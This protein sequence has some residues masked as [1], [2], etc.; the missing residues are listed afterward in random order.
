MKTFPLLGGAPL[1]PGA[2]IVAPD[3]G[4]ILAEL[5][6]AKVELMYALA[7]HR[8]AWARM[9]AHAEERDRRSATPNMLS[10]LESDPIWKKATGDVS[11]WRGEMVAQS[12][13]I[14]ALTAMLPKSGLPR[15][16]LRET[17]PEERNETT[18]SIVMHWIESL[19][20]TEAQ[21]SAAA[22]WIKASAHLGGPKGDDGK[23]GRLIDRWNGDRP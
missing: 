19:P 13:A 17:T 10:T 18:R 16:T 9:R 7:M 14:Q 8:K 11:W 22:H 21:A 23:C 4:P 6:R 2:P 12:A 15:E 5:T 1:E 3:S 20:P